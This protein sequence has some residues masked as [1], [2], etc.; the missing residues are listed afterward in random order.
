MTITKIEKQKNN[1]KRYSIYIDNNFSFGLNEEDLLYLKLKE[2]DEITINRYNYIM[3]YVVYTKAKDRAYRFL[4][5]K[6]RTE[7]ELRDKLLDELYPQEIVNRII[8]LFKNYNYI[9]DKNYAQ[10]HINNRSKFKPMAKRMLKY[11]LMKKGIDNSIIETTIENSNVNELDIAV[12]L[13]EKKIKNKTDL[14]KKEK[15]RVYNFLLRRGFDYDT[16]NKAFNLVLKKDST[17]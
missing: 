7:K 3:E 4:G 13:L 17:I 5:Y 8:E 1:Q 15:E 9:N 2:F 10:G 6:A 12:Q 14:D 16:V 11:E